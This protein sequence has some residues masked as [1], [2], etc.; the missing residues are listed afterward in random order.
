FVFLLRV[1]H[2]LDISDQA[3]LARKKLQQLPDPL[4][5]DLAMDVFDE[6]ERRELNTSII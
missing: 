4:F 2:S 1:F 6:V 3:L 5:E